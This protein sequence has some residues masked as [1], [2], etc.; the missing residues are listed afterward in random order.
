VAR[1]GPFQYVLGDSRREAAR[2]DGQA[3]LWDPVAHALFD[4]IGVRPGWRVLEVGPGRGSV[5]LDLRRRVQ[6]PIDA[7]ERSPAFANALR[8]RCARDGFDPGRVWGTDLL[9]AD[10]PANTYD[11]V[12]ARWVFC[13]L[14]RPAAHLQKLVRA[15]RPGGLIALQDY[16]HRAS[17]ALCPRPAEWADFLAADRSLF[18][19][20]GG[21][22]DIV[23]RLALLMRATAMDVT[24]VTP[25]VQMGRPGSNVWDWLWRYFLSVRDRL[26][27]IR[28]LTP[29]KA[30]RLERQ[31]REAA[32][33]P[34][35]FVIAPVVADVVARRR[36]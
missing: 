35:A 26:A 4:R 24:E 13:F 27:A 32:R 14:P 19:S 11:L 16:A 6:G 2:L 17:F 10:L 7:V 15:V 5:H 28:P 12:Y 21:D 9:A 18:A 8:R 1:R 3:R 30:A 20:H 22:I 25:L 23:G 29:A 36:G 33:D 31:W 34:Q